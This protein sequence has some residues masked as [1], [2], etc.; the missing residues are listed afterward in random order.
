MSRQAVRTLTLTTLIALLLVSCVGAPGDVME[1][2]N[3][4]V[5][6]DTGAAEGALS[7]EP[8]GESGSAADF[9]IQE[10]C[11]VGGLQYWL[12]TPENAA[13]GM[14]MIVY[15][16]GG[17]G[18]GSQPELI[19][20]EE[21]LPRYLQTGLLQPKAYV[22]I[23]QLPETYRG[24]EEA[25]EPLMQLIAYLETACGVDGTRVSLTG[26]SMGGVGVWK[27]AQ[28]FPGFFSCI[29]PLSGSVQT[30]GES[31]RLL[32]ETPVWAFV[33]DSD[34]VVSPDSSIR[35]VEAL[36]KQG[37]SAAVTVL[38]DTDHFGVPAAVDLNGDMDVIGWMLEQSRQP[39]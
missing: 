12:Y 37:A 15:L 4:S 16:H 1:P 6:G 8:S 21:S 35:A 10:P 23:P 20:A 3:S 39:S 27:L 26:H 18:K 28:E 36:R 5:A 38:E 25:A 32:S 19:T 29:V 34:T 14:P 24:W 2:W 33:G 17:S 13:P 22:V 7:S 9:S 31:L 11:A 30:T